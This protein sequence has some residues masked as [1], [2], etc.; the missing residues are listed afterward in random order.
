MNTNFYNHFF[1][2][3]NENIIIY[4]GEFLSDD[5]KDIVT[6]SVENL[7][8]NCKSIYDQK[9]YR[10]NHCI[11]FILSKNI[12]EYN[13]VTTIKNVFA[14]AT[15]KEIFRNTLRMY[16]GIL[17]NVATTQRDNPER[18]D[19]KTEQVALRFALRAE[20]PVGGVVAAEAAKKP[21]KP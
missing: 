15:N 7:F 1:Y 6:K 13:V 8:N 2:A 16:P 20:W 19:G 18:V 9:I 3:A 21:A 14:K 12:P 5:T 4:N 10:S 11:W 17:Q